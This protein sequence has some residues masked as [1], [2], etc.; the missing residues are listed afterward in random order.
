MSSATQPLTPAVEGWCSEHGRYV[1]AACPLCALAAR[2]PA[3]I[4]ANPYELT[5]QRIAAALER[6]AAAVDMR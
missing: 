3:A 1:G 6:I 2:N 5:L 4:W